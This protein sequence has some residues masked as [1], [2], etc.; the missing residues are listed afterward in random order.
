[1]HARAPTPGVPYVSVTTFN[2]DL[3]RYDDPKTVAAVG[4]ADADVICL[5]E[6]NDAWAE[7]LREHY[8]ERYP[9][10]AFR[11]SGSGGLAVL[12]RHPFE[13]LGLLEGVEGWHPAWSVLVDSPLGPLQILLVHL[14]PPVNAR[15]GVAGYFQ[16]DAR[17]T[18]EVRSFSQ[19][20]R[21]D[22]AT[23]VVGDFNT[24]D[25]PALD[26][27]EDRGYRSVLPLFRPGQETWR[28]DKGLV[29]QTIDTLDH[30]FFDGVLDPLDAY[31]LYEGRS[32]H[33]PVTALFERL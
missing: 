10:M 13:D 33:L 27:L 18:K 19:S 12:S 23:L 15:D 9:F 31:V 6:T 4:A 30:I 24:S 26:Y 8:A 1:M 2:V 3:A 7:V 22:L 25:G 29:G 11:G 17:Q 21:S 16:A 28:Y 5:Q 32:D 14:R 20:L